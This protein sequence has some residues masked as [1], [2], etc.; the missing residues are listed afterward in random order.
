MLRVAILTES[1]VWGGLETHAI[2]LADALVSAGFDASIVCVGEQTF[3]LYREVAGRSARLVHVEPPKSKAMRRNPFSWYAALRGV[4]A[5]A[6]ILEKGTLN[7]GGF[8]LDLAIRTRFGP[9]LAI[10]QLEPPVLPARTSRRHV[11]GVLP[12]LG[13]WWYRWRLRGY[14]RSLCPAMTVCVSDSVRR[15]LASQYGFAERRLVT[16]RHGIDLDRFRPDPDR[17]R[18]ARRAWGVPPDSIV[19]GSVR[20]FVPD[21]GLDVAIDAFATAL[22]SS[23]DK[24]LHLILVGE[25]P[26]QAALEQQADRLGV[27]Q[28]VKFVGFSTSPWELYPG[29]DTF[30]L[31]SR[32]E[33]LGVVA[34]EAMACGCEVIGSNVGGIPEMISD[35]TVGTLV[36]PGDSAQLA[37]A[38]LRSVARN[39]DE[40]TALLQRARDHVAHGFERRAQCLRIAALLPAK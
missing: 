39:Q 5:D 20:R 10:E 3:A 29:F 2:S 37:K 24:P 27:S 36:S 1:H 15:A 19:F 32:V 11:G 12:G 9:Y 33:A 23:R 26:E 17:R 40:R 28:Y 34:L 18:S 30:L 21:K 38:M 7:T 6:A 35:E 16:I 22:A 13:L 4:S 31:P 25:G 14:V 8:A